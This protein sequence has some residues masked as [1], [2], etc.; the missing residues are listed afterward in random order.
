MNNA[1]LIWITNEYE[2]G[3]FGMGGAFIKRGGYITSTK[4][5]SESVLAE[6][7]IRW[8]KRAGMADFF[9]IQNLAD[10]SYHIK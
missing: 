10:F 1:E 4:T 3:D 5:F 6:Y 7:G 9:Y 2:L 8:I